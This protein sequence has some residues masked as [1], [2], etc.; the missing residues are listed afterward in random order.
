MVQMQGSE[1]IKRHTKK[2]E[3]ITSTYAYPQDEDKS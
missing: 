3:I 1:N 2:M